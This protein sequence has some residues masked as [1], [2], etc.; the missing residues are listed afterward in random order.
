MCYQHAMSGV[1]VMGHDASLQHPDSQSGMHLPVWL[2]RTR[3][4]M[5]QAHMRFAI[6]TYCLI[7]GHTWHACVVG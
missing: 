6:E 1:G 4:M 5:L 2:S 7:P 3:L